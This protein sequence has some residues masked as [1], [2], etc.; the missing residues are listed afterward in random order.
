MVL[1]LEDNQLT[2]TDLVAEVCKQLHCSKEILAGRLRERGVKISV[3]SFYK[4]SRGLY[5]PSPN[6]ERVIREELVKILEDAEA[7]ALSSPE[8]AEARPS[9]EIP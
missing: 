2:F 5:K 8:K 6:T 9:Q 4:W 3:S 1:Y 7:R